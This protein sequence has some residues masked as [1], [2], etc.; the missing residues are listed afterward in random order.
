[1]VSPSLQLFQLVVLWVALAVAVDLAKAAV[2]SVRAAV[3]G[4]AR[5]AVDLVKVAVDLAKVVVAV[6]LVRAV[7]VVISSR[8]IPRALE[9]DFISRQ[10]KGFFP[11]L[12]AQHFK[13]VELEIWVAA[14]L[15]VV[16]L[17]VANLAAVD[18]VA[19]NLVAVVLV[20]A[21]LVAANLVAADL[22]VKVVLVMAIMACKTF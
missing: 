9:I 1:M 2:A 12:V 6:D 8:K 3:A 7:V 11:E 19:A 13:V 17:V 18:L 15:A 20:A 14:D 22:V 16:G 5:V 4:L 10:R 21:N